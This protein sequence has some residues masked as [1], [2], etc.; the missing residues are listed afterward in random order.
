MLNNNNNNNNNEHKQNTTKG[1][2]STYLWVHHFDSYKLKGKSAITNPP[3]TPQ[4]SQ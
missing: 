3:P 1:V 4:W 2:E